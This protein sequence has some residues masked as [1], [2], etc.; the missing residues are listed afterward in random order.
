MKTCLIV[1]DSNVIRKVASHI[2]E[3]LGCAL[4]EAE[5]G[6]AAIEHCQ[7]QMPDVVLLDWNL[8]R[9]S[10]IDFITALR[11][12][13]NGQKPVVFYCTTENDPIDIAR[14]LSAGGDDYIMKPY[15]RAGVHAKFVEAG[16]A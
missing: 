6:E 3:S 4:N 8:P 13:P 14:A 10:G 9:M 5:S 15:D 7:Q 1:D 2:L 16:L 12:L 11:R